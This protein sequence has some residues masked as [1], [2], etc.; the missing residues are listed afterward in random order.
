MTD[1][2]LKDRKHGRLR[3]LRSMSCQVLCAWFSPSKKRCSDVMSHGKGSMSYFMVTLPG[4][5]VSSFP[6]NAHIS[7]DG[8]LGL[9]ERQQH[10]VNYT[11]CVS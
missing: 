10:T 6:W 5:S 1:E 4:F 7:S 2:E 8:V 3:M 9:A 11:M